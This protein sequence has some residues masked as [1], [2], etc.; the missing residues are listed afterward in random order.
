MTMTM[1]K[2]TTMANTTTTTTTTTEKAEKEEGEGVGKGGRK[3]RRGRRKTSSVKDFLG[4]TYRTIPTKGPPTGSLVSHLKPQHA[5]F[6]YI[7]TG[8]NNSIY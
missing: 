8:P 7:L 1:T 3:G 5:F 4:L 2:A 6:N